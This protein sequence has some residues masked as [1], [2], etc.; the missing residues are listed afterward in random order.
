LATA[1]LTSAL[2]ADILPFD[3]AASDTRNDLRYFHKDRDGRL[4]NGGALA[5]QT[6]AHARLSRLVKVK[7]SSTF[8]P[9][10]AMNFDFF[11]GGRTA[12]TTDRL[13]R[14]HRTSDGLVSWI[15]CNGRGL[16]LAMGM[17][18]V[19]R[20]AVCGALDAELALTPCPLAR[21]PMHW[22]VKRTARLALLHYRRR[23]RW[24]FAS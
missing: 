8:P 23:D 7:L 12:M 18:H 4:V 19:V 1:P 21:V 10:A 14:P 9:L 17:G 3:E 11:W 2:A 24:E 22:L 6:F 16:A 20:D 13:P 5:F 15:G